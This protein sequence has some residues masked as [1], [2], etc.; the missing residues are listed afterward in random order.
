MENI[1]S[2]DQ[3][4]YYIKLLKH[5]KTVKS[6]FLSFSFWTVNVWYRTLPQPM[7]HDTKNERNQIIPNDIYEQS[8][9][10][11]EKGPVYVSVQ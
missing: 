4:L 8:K 9:H 6:F 7:L 1:N 10:V 11:R 5:N 2:H 3:I